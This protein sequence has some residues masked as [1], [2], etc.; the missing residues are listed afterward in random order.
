MMVKGKQAQRRLR[1]QAFDQ[2]GT[3]LEQPLLQRRLLRLGQDLSFSH[4]DVGNNLRS[5][6]RTRPKSASPRTRC[7]RRRI[8]PVRGVQKAGRRGRGGEARHLPPNAGVAGLACSPTS[9]SH[10]AALDATEQK[11]CSNS[12]ALQ[13]L[14]V[15]P[16]Q[17]PLA[18]AECWGRSYL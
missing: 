15:L 1:F 11:Q 6:A 12:R 13:R 3:H 5:K 14:P 2:L 8:P 18:P 10:L 17:M 4:Q 9:S 16:N 7:A